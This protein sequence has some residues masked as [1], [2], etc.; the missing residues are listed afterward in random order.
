MTASNPISL[1]SRALRYLARR[2]HTRQELEKKLSGHDC[3]Q[4]AITAL[5][6]QLEQDGYLSNE[7]FAEQVT[8][9]RRSKF[10]SRRIV[11]ELKEKGVEEH[12]IADILPELKVT[13]FETARHI[14]QKKFGTPP[15]D[16][17]E[18]GKQIRF[19]M[20]RGFSLDTINTVLLQAEKEET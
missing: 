6:D 4:Q 1:E 18:R 17:K 9:M 19:M 3:S 8:Q 12:V 11:H 5:L 2:E 16:F 7:R 20:N 14:W 13:D 10:G 15:G